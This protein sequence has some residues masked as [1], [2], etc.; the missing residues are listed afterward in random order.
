MKFLKISGMISLIFL[1]FFNSGIPSSALTADS[2]SHQ[3]KYHLSSGKPTPQI[4]RVSANPNH[5]Y[6]Y[7]YKQMFLRSAGIVRY[8]GGKYVP[9]ADRLIR[10]L[11]ANTFDFAVD[12]SPAYTELDPCG[13]RIIY[14]SKQQFFNYDSPEK[15]T[16]NTA[17]YLAS[18]LVHELVHYDQPGDIFN[19]DE[20]I[21]EPPACKEELKFLQALIVNHKVDPQVR[22]EAA[23]LYKSD[24]EEFT[25]KG[26]IKP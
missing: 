3:G 10:L 15:M 18:T 16:T 5:L 24:K 21:K 2:F 23:R 6:R 12:A 9:A 20:E 22:S 8:A 7:P 19:A 11:I 1:V 4:K 13:G 25:S 14:L 26:F 17:V